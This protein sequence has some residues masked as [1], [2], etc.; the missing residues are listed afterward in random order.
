MA[1][2]LLYQTTSDELSKRVFE[3]GLLDKNGDY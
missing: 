3:W 2:T 1:L